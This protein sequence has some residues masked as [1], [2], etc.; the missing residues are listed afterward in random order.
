[1]MINTVITSF[2]EQV[3]GTLVI[4]TGDE[5]LHFLVGMQS[6][7]DRVQLMNYSTMCLPV[8]CVFLSRLPIFMVI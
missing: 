8:V 5:G 3:Y 1:M 6:D 2:C 7:G 4:I